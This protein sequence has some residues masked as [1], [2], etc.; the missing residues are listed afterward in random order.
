MYSLHQ[1]SDLGPVIYFSVI[2]AEETFLKRTAEEMYYEII[3]YV[4]RDPW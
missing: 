3:D 2:V 4:S 1:F